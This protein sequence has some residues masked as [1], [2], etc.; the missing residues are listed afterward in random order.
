MRKTSFRESE[1]GELGTVYASRESL[2]EIYYVSKEV[3]ISLDEI[4]ARAAALTSVE[5]LVFLDTTYEI[6]LL[7]LALIKRYNLGSI[8]DAYYAA[9]VLNQVPDRVI[10]SADTVFDRIP[11]LVRVDPRE[12]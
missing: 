11:G 1:E 12:L 7:A 6:D 8:F 3:G 10:K 2:H 4:V 9:T 5:N